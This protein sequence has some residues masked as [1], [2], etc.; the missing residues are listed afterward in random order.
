PSSSPP[1]G[2]LAFGAPRP[3][4]VRTGPYL[5]KPPQLQHTYYTLPA[6]TYILHN[7]SFNILTTNEPI[8]IQE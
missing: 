2:R 6:S 1:C 4:S 8:T 7:S 3:G 5:R